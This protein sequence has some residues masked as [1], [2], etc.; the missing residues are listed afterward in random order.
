MR[1][2]GRRDPDPEPAPVRRDKVLKYLQAE[3]EHLDGN[4]DDDRL[5]RKLNEASEGLTPAEFRAAHEAAR[6]HG[7]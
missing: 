1:L 4:P 5:Y 6:R 7:Y 3:L 2:F